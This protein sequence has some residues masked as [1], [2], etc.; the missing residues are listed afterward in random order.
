LCID[1][2]G[3]NHSCCGWACTDCGLCH[4]ARGCGGD[5]AIAF[6]LT[7]LLCCLSF[8]RCS[9]WYSRSLCGTHPLFRVRVRVRVRW[10]VCGVCGGMCAVCA[11]V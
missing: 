2:P 5:N 6:P 11:V 7:T 4:T 8:G 1:V 9:S 10:H 3:S